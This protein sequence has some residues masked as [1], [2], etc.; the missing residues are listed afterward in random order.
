[1]QTELI[2]D[3]ANTKRPLLII[4]HESAAALARACALLFFLPAEACKSFLQ[5]KIQ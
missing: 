1:M 5:A 4:D 2:G 3:V